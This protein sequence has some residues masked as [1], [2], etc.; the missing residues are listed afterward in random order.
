MTDNSEDQPD[1]VERIMNVALVLLGI[2]LCVIIVVCLAG[3]GW[4]IVAPYFGKEV[5]L[6]TPA[7]SD[8]KK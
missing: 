2:L 3:I 1:L 5:S 8:V 7:L 6:S 4:I